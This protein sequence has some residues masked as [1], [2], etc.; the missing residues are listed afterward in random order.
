MAHAFGALNF[1][2]RLSKDLV[3]KQQSGYMMVAVR[4]SIGLTLVLLHVTTT[5]MCTSAQTSASLRIA[6]PLSDDKLLP[7]DD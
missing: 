3:N 4:F 5:V 1:Y 7:S 6:V 2:C